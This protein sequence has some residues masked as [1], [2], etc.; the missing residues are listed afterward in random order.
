[1][2][3]KVCTPSEAKPD[4]NPFWEEVRLSGKHAYEGVG[5]WKCKSCQTPA[6]YF[7]NQIYDDIWQYWCTITPAELE[8]LC[9]PFD[10]ETDELQ[11]FARKLIDGRAVLEGHPVFGLQWVH[12]CS[13]LDGPRW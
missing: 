6:M 3:C 10:P 7:S 11:T 9:Q 5:L 2:T 8:R 1:M 12:N 13:V 4:S